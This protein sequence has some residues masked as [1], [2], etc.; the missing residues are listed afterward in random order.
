VWWGTVCHHRA[1]TYFQKRHSTPFQCKRHK[2]GE[3][4]WAEL[5]WA[6]VC[7]SPNLWEGGR[8]FGSL[9]LPCEKSPCPRCL[10]QVD[11]GTKIAETKGPFAAVFIAGERAFGSL[12]QTRRLPPPIPSL[13]GQKRCI[14]IAIP[15]CVLLSSMEISTRFLR[16]TPYPSC[17]A[18]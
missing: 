14:P 6:E 3:G 8:S 9:S 1:G 17:I 18:S 7:N 12:P 15:R 13:Q 11:P 10:Q 4:S 5:S 16:F 2:Q